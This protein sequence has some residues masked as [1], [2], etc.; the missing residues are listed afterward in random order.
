MASLSLQHELS[1]HARTIGRFSASLVLFSC[2]ATVSAQTT[3]TNTV[4]NGGL[5]NV[6][7]TEIIKA[8]IGMAVEMSDRYFPALMRVMF[9]DITPSEAMNSWGLDHQMNINENRIQA[10]D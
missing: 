8:L 9:A 7:D 10:G 5:I 1:H 3:N 6:G 4:T 2:L